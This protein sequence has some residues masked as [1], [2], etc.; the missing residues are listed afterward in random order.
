MKDIKV[1]VGNTIIINVYTNKTNNT[2][3]MKYISLNKNLN[4]CSG[5]K[6]ANRLREFQ[7]TKTVCELIDFDFEPT[8]INLGGPCYPNL[9]KIVIQGNRDRL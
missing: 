4:I 5:L 6:G 1:V 9:S 8:L 2:C 7:I 3:R